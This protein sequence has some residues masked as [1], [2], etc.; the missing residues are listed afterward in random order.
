MILQNPN[1]ETIFE[2]IKGNYGTILAALKLFLTFN[3]LSLDFH[4]LSHKLSVSEAL[5]ILFYYL[6]VLSFLVIEKPIILFA[7][8]EYPIKE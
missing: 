1:L 8:T 7:L 5:D 3:F 2:V 4:P 6:L